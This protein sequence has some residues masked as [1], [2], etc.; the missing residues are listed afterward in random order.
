M[1]PAPAQPLADLRRGQHACCLYD[2]APRALAAVAPFVAAGLAAGE[3]CVYVLGD[4][5]AG[6]VEAAIAAAGVEVARERE[7]GALVLVDRWEVA[8]PDGRFDP[9]AMIVYVRAGI[10]GALAAGFSGLRV[11][12]EMSWAL[13]MGVEHNR[14]IHYEALGN[15]LYPDQ[16]LV[17]VCLY[18]RSRFPAAVCQNALRVHPFVAVD[19]TTYPNLYYEMPE[20]GPDGSGADDRV[21]WMLAQLRKLGEAERQQRELLVARAARREAEVALEA[22]DE[23]LA[24]LAHEL[25]TPLAAMRGRVEVSLQSIAGG[26]PEDPALLRRQ[27]EGMARQVRKQAR[28]I[29][30]VMTAAQTSSGA[31]PLDRRPCDLAELVEE[32]VAAAGATAPKHRFEVRTEGLA[33][34]QADPLRLEQ[35]L[36]NL[37]DNAVKFSPAGSR[38]EVEVAAEGDAVVLAV[39]DQGPGVPAAQRERIFDRYVSVDPEGR[40]L[41]LGL[42][43]SREIVRRHGGELTVEPASGGGSRFVAR[44]PAAAA[45]EA[46]RS[47]TGSGRAAKGE[48]AAGPALAAPGP[49]ARSY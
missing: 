20:V 19:D 4:H 15:A 14:L 33:P 24:T 30:Q 6:D 25:R 38:I 17:A 7:R 49:P 36:T 11:V 16:P 9:A 35:V 2:Q 1:E 40:G 28:L 29:E 22:R 46:A 31:L 45:G 3:R 12:A 32:A 37:L 44:L 23:L 48:P 5:P 21:E 8:F 39:S 43:V 10:T 13:Q 26:L 41:G 27:L 18:D 42:Y 47:R 34:L